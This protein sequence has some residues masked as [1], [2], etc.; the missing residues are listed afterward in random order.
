VD[1]TRGD[2]PTD[3]TIIKR[4]KN[5][6]EYRQTDDLRK[7]DRKRK[8]NI[9]FILL[10]M[11]R[12]ST[13]LTKRN[14]TRSGQNCTRRHCAQSELALT[15][16]KIVK[17][18]NARHLTNSNKSDECRQQAARFHRPVTTGVRHKLLL[19]DERPTAAVTW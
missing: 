16:R 19:V 8:Q 17:W 5:A 1:K 14:E 2:T 11:A 9:Y 13:G 10:N 7:H 6:T 15:G 3:I 18:A 12:N 4:L